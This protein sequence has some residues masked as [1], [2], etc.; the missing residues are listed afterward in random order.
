M[1]LE[2]V[3]SVGLICINSSTEY[4]APNEVEESP[5]RETSVFM[6]GV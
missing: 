3:F 1:Q 5:R 6:R 4:I 2:W